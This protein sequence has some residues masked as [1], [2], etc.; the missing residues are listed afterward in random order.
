[1]G[2]ASLFPLAATI[3]IALS[4][5]LMVTFRRYDAVISWLPEW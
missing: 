5:D 1:M 2:E 4:P 3:T